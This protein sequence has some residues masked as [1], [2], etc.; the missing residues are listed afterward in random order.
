MLVASCR[1][2][3]N[4]RGN[5]VRVCGLR[6]DVAHLTPSASHL[7]HSKQIQ[8]LFGISRPAITA[9]EYYCT[10]RIIKNSRWSSHSI[11]NLTFVV[12]SSLNFSIM[13]STASVDLLWY[14]LNQP[15]IYTVNEIR[16]KKNLTFEM[17]EDNI[18][19]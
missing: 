15:P 4:W 16:K 3:I 11:K 12:R 17:C 13:K 5:A 1:W 9:R 8:R 6:G 2:L 10:P 19:R 7:L 18:N 14:L